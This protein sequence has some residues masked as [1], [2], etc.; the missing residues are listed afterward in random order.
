MI[1]APA[2]TL[3]VE[4][5]RV[6][7]VYD[8][9]AG[10]VIALDQID[11]TIARGELIAI[12]GPSGCGKTTLLNCLSGLDEVTSGEVV[13]EG[14]TMSSMSDAKRT[15]YRARRM[16]FIFQAFNL[17]P[18]FSAAE[19]VEL[20]LLLVGT[21]ASKARA[22]A[23]EAL[24]S[25]GLSQRSVNRPTE[26]SAGEQQRVAIARAI[27]PDPAVLWADEPTGNLDSENADRILLLLE[28]LN[29]E[30]DLT[31]AMVTHDQAIGERAKRLVH[32][33]DGRLGA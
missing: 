30:R 29:R 11:L 33:R 6:S 7:R 4:A 15:S 13:V 3:M 20:P 10:E 32:M 31:V 1:V 9:G 2:Q 17:L 5:R 28:T 24:D 19:N 27:A 18:V 25:V 12:M 21:R 26:L 22:R 14:T 23:L 8:S 16:G